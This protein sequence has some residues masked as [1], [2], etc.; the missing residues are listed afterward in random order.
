MEFNEYQKAALRTEAERATIGE[1]LNHCQIGLHT[2]AG[3]FATVVKRHIFYGKPLTE[4]MLAN[5]KEELGDAMWYL[6]I[7]AEALGTTLEQLAIDN[8]AKLRARFPD[9]FSTEAAEA[10]ADKGGLDARS[11]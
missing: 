3:E 2:E 7:G 1:R 4:E 6:A 5:A 9:K 11:S 8:I 10:R